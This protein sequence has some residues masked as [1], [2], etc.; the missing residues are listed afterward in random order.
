MTF[1][2]LENWFCSLSVW[3][4]LRLI[5]WIFWSEIFTRQKLFQNIF[6]KILYKSRLSSTK[7]YK[8][9]SYFLHFYSRVHIANKKKSHNFQ[10]SI[11]NYAMRKPFQKSFQNLFWITRLFLKK[12][13]MKCKITIHKWLPDPRLHNFSYKKVIVMIFNVNEVHEENTGCKKKC[14]W[15]N[16]FIRQK[17]TVPRY[18]INY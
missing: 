12:L 10:K 8:I 17:K 7:I 16:S 6:S 14:P 1:F 4:L 5:H 11:I 13:L 18:D 3:D 15:F 2:F 9:L